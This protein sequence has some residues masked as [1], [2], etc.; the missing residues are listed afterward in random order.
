MIRRTYNERFSKVLDNTINSLLDVTTRP[1]SPII[2]SLRAAAITS[3]G[4]V[5]EK[6]PLRMTLISDMVQNTAAVSQ[7]HG[8]PDFQTLAHTMTWATLRPDLH[9][10]DV[11]I[12]YLLRPS[13]AAQGRANTKSGPSGFLGTAYRREWR[14]PVS[15][16]TR[17]EGERKA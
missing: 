6:I 4:P 14:P 9:D 5:T 12:L 1:N 11:T 3:F 16:S 17:F 10:A 7:Y 15:K 8:A 2:E 13:G